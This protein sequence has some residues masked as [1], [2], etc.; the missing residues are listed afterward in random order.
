MTQLWTPDLTVEQDRFKR[1]LFKI[2][3]KIASPSQLIL[4]DQCPAKWKFQKETTPRPPPSPELF[5]GIIVDAAVE[6][7]LQ[8][9]IEYPDELP[10]LADAEKVFDDKYDGG[11]DNVAWRD[12]TPDSFADDAWN[13]VLSVYEHII[14][15][16]VT[17]IVTQAPLH[18]KLNEGT[19]KTIGVLMFADWIEEDPNFGLVITDLKTGGRAPTEMK[20]DHWFQTMLY[21]LGY[22]KATGIEADAI[23]TVNL[24]RG[25]SSREKPPV[26][27][28]EKVTKAGIKRATN[29]MDKVISRMTTAKEHEPNRNHPFCTQRWCPYHE[30][31]V[32]KYGGKVRA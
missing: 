26:V 23:R 3:W 17:P 11:A 7:L 20:E 18:C 5:F 9:V 13:C 25:V 4:Y 29:R 8:G 31:C 10:D 24:V 16:G 12:D 21:R 19:D 14:T 2:C 28:T 6:R 15:P 27:L 22:L 30:R 1:S 32:D